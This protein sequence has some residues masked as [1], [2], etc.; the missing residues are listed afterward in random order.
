MTQS[1]ENKLAITLRQKGDALYLT[2]DGGRLGQAKAERKAP[3]ADS[4]EKPDLLMANGPSKDVLTEVGEIL[5][6]AL[7]HGDVG[8]LLGEFLP[9]SASGSLE[10]EGDH[11]SVD[12][13]LRFD[14]D[15]TD[16]CRYPW[17]CIRDRHGRFLVQAGLA[18]LTRTILY[19]QKVPA[20]DEDVIQG[21]ILQ[22]ISQPADLAPIVANTLALDG[23]KRLEHASFEAFRSAVLTHSAEVSCLQFDGHGALLKCCICGEPNAM[24]RVNCS[25][26]GTE[27]GTRSGTAFLMFERDAKR[28]PVEVEVLGAV[29]GRSKVRFAC[30]LACE[31]ARLDGKLVFTGYS[32]GLILCGVPAVLGM[33][34]PI[35]NDFAQAFSNALFGALRD[36]HSLGKAVA[37][38][39]TATVDKTWFTPALYTR[40]APPPD[41]LRTLQQARTV[42]TAAPSEVV[43]GKTFV[44][45]LR[46]RRADSPSLT[47]SALRKYLG[48]A[49]EVELVEASEDMHVRL[50]APATGELLQGEVSV[51]LTAHGCDVNPPECPVVVSENLDGPTALFQITPRRTGKLVLIFRLFQ[52]E[53]QVAALSFPIDSA[54]PGF[55]GR[56][57]LVARRILRFVS[58]E[59]AAQLKR[60]EF[61]LQAHLRASD[62]LVQ[63]F[64]DSRRR[65]GSTL[66]AAYRELQTVEERGWDTDRLVAD[67]DSTEFRR[68]DAVRIQEFIRGLSRA[69]EGQEVSSRY[70]DRLASLGR[71]L[72]EVG[73]RDLAREEWFRLHEE[74]AYLLYRIAGDIGPSRL[75]AAFESLAESHGLLWPFG[76]P[77]AECVRCGFPF[78]EEEAWLWPHSQHWLLYL[79]WH[80][81]HHDLPKCPRCGADMVWG[82]WSG[83]HVVGTI[84]KASREL[85][86]SCHETA[87]ALRRVLS[88]ADQVSGGR[89]TA[90][91]EAVRVELR[92][93]EHC[94]DLT[95]R[96]HQACIDFLRH[97][98]GARMASLRRQLSDL[99]QLVR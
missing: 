3:A 69:I 31:T 2:A 17:E 93:I 81:R 8:K 42:E 72:D 90:R 36:G 50:E 89:E 20:W 32:P 60:E 13:E 97:G 94:S 10:G 40:F 30:L 99:I 84:M 83:S 59:R 25:A 34:Y 7:S 23:A 58:A 82:P 56:S 68:A 14:E 54:D 27:L 65:V 37:K 12:I 48:L 71:S 15:Q 73:Q 26:C 46:M 22:V 80:L 44:A 39:R 88:A 77:G 45:L 78:D 24:D 67:P 18:S 19:P 98:G 91:T 76:W 4:I 61:E 87:D 6:G 11:Q 92:T 16:L 70:L 21:G 64:A 51:R 63:E 57:V 41:C 95:W 86:R 1:S 28:E 38:A 85:T 33:Q 55:V 52:R 29:L 9:A 79:K 75:V 53:L 35:T 74:V 62:T 5:Y 47:P 49:A 66:V 96:T 43:A